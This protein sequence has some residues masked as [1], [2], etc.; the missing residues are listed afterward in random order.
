[1]NSSTDDAI[2]HVQSWAAE[3]EHGAELLATT[4]DAGERARTAL[5][6]TTSSTLGAVARH[7]GGILVAGGWLRIYGAGHPR[8]RRRVHRFAAELGLQGAIAIADDAVGGIFAFFRANE[9][10]AYFGPDTLEWESLDMDYG[11]WLGAMLGGAFEGFYAPFQ[12]SGWEQEL[13]TLGPDQVWSFEP[14]LALEGLPARERPR[15]VVP[16]LEYWRNA[17][18][19]GGKLH[20]RDGSPEAGTAG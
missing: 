3:C 10:V 18:T 14:M 4:W 6:L 17:R 16:L 12:W 2:F 7:T 1:M 5:G 20:G 13:Q 9:S 8:L 15:T 19:L 11:D